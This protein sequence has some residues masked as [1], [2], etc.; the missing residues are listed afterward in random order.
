MNSVSNSRGDARATRFGAAA[1]IAI[2]LERPLMRVLEMIAALLVAA[3]VAI[4]LIGVIARYVF[5]HP[6]IWT[7]EGAQA[8][9]LWLGMIGATVALNRGEHMRMT[10]LI[11]RARP[12]PQLVLDAFGAAM[13]L[14]FLAVVI[15][16]SF[17]YINEVSRLEMPGLGVSKLWITLPLPI[18]F[19]ILFAVAAMRLFR[20]FPAWLAGLLLVLAVAAA[21]FAPLADPWLEWLGNLNLLL[22][23]V[24]LVGASILAGV[25]IAIAF[26]V[27]TFAY[28]VLTTDVPMLLFVGRFYEGM[29]HLIL[30][31][32]PLFVFLGLL[33]EMTGMARAMVNFLASLLGHVR[34]GLSYVLVGA[35][36]LVSG[37][38][39][40]KAADMAAVAPALFPEM[41]KRGA[42]PGDLVALLAATGAQTETVP[43]RLVLITIGSVTGVSIG[44]LFT[45]GM[46][47]SIVLAIGLCLVVR[48]R[49]RTQDM[50][51]VRRSTGPEIGRAFVVALPALA[52]PFVIRFMVVEGVATAAEVSTIGIAYTVVIGL[53]IY[54]QFTWSRI[55]PMLVETAA[56]SGAILLILGAAT[57]MAWALTQSGFSQQLA[58]AMTGLPGGRFS[59]LGVSIVAFVV[60]GSVLEGIPVIVLFGPLLF[61]IAQKMGIHEIHYAMVTVLAM[62]IGLFAP[63]FGV[64]F[65]AAA[66]IGRVDPNLGIR[67]ILA[68][69]VAMLIGLIVVAA[70]PW[71][72]IGFL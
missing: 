9:F 68:Y 37:I 2:S 67:P 19:V 31:A 49:Y 21:W 70:V 32:V 58:D 62:G 41:I 29:S 53:L 57:S 63:P 61:P 56:L 39:G 18:G 6:L 4:M 11:A 40:S 26:A 16:P 1:A 66:A 30:L 22:F 8:V 10:A 60:L 27:G 24:G 43:P 51:G 17:D 28:M 65:Y 3:E 7:D 50:S 47:P 59:F 54:R 13:G 45:G 46:L 44:A 25:P 42:A 5:R 38:S 23:F 14:V 64:G 72:S 36:Y 12:V 71:I 35:M 20:Q 55:V 33:I 15:Q 69:M 34:G 52:L 48:R